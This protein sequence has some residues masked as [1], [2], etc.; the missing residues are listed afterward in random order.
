MIIVQLQGGLGNQMFQD[1]LGRSLAQKMDAALKLDLTNFAEYPGRKYAL[2]KFDI[3]ASIATRADLQLARKY[4]FPGKVVA[5]LLGGIL[6]GLRFAVVRESS[7]RF[8]ADVLEVRGSIYLAGYW[9]SEKYFKPIEAAIREE[10]RLEKAC[11]EAGAGPGS[12]PG[13]TVPVSVHV[14]R[15]D[16]VSDPAAARLLGALPMDYYRAA[17]Q[18]IAERVRNAQFFVFTDDPDWAREHVQIGQPVTLVAHEGPA[19]DLLDM[20]RMSA[21][22]H[23]IIA[24]STFS[25]WAAWLNPDPGKIVV[26]PKKWYRD[27]SC[28]VSDLILETWERI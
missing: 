19:S 24:N 20:Y 7:T 16:Y 3:R 26:A 4:G 1:A 15:G 14:R 13:D 18:S 21:C 10:F 9:Q 28:D 23:N 17:A 22:R 25:W 6:P 8:N 12:A 11:G 2:D 27:P 5:P